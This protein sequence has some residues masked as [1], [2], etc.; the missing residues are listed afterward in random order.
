MKRGYVVALLALVVGLAG[1]GTV[2]SMSRL[3]VSQPLEFSHLLHIEDI[4]AECV[5]C[6][7]YA[8]SGERATIPN[9]PVCADCHD[10]VYGESPEEA[11]V[12]E[13]VQSGEV[14]PWQK[15]YWVPD[16]VYFSHRRHTSVAEVECEAC[17]GPVGTR[18]EPVTRRLVPITMDGCRDCHAQSEA[19]NDCIVCH[20]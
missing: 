20:R 14:I 7:L 3:E 4:G 19:S 10:E 5:D 9:I 18:V 13:Y 8:V 17:H 15:V 6:H 16:H 11:R 1:A 12:V 2:M